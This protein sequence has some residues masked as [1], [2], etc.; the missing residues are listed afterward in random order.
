MIE[1]QIASSISGTL[2]KYP[3]LTV[4]G[5]RQSGK[6]TLLKSLFP[7]WHYVSMET[8]DIRQQVLQNPRGLFSRYGH[9]IVIDEVQRTPDLLSYIQTIV[10]ED[11]NASFV[12]SGSHNLLMLEHISQSLAGRTAIFYLLPLSLNELVNADIDVEK[13]EELIFRGF[14]P[15]I[16]D[17]QL[18]ATEFYPNYLE[19]YVQRDVRQIKNVGNLSLFNRFLSICAGHIGQTINYSNIA[20]DTGVSVSTIQNW[21]SVLE[22][23]FIIYR[24]NP[25]YRNFNKRITKAPKLYFYDT[26]LACSLLRIN[27]VDALETYYQKGALFENFVINEI[28]KQYYNRGNRPPIYYWKDSNQNEIDLIIDL[29]GQLIPVEIKS[30]R[31][32]SSQFF[33]TL[34]WFQDVSSLPISNSYVIYGGEQDWELEHGKLLSWKHFSEIIS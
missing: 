4:T 31:T 27:N 25:Y 18:R 14:Y 17:R 20:N 10:D 28:C 6:T 5:P 26:G 16:Y 22:T 30:A 1:R 33:K 2:G 11:P 15:R 29:G 12:L 24:L 9:R 13:Y 3:V 19:T 21:L 23:S 7:D 8:P 32:F 34:A